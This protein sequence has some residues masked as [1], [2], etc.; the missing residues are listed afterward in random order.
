MA[1]Q[2]RAHH[3]Q[4]RYEQV[5]ERC[6]RTPEHCTRKNARARVKCCRGTRDGTAVNVK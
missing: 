6:A 1:A 3:T 2:L 4:R 5:H